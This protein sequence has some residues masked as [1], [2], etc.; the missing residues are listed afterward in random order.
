M[1]NYSCILRLIFFIS[2][3]FIANGNAIAQKD[4][5][6]FSGVFNEWKPYRIY[7]PAAYPQSKEKYPVIYFFHG[8][9]G[10]HQFAVE[11]IQQLVNENKVIFVAWNGRSVPS[12]MR[13]YN[14]GYHS[15][16]KYQVQF[17]DYFPEFI[18]YID[19]TYRT[20][21]DRSHRAIMGHSMGGFMSFF[22]AGK[23][24]QLVG[25][26]VS[27]K[28][29]S[30]FFI[31]YPANHSLYLV[32][33]MF[34][35]FNGV[36]LRFH[37]STID[38]LVHL[39]TEVYN[40]AKREH[41]LNLDY[42]VYPG[43][44]AYSVSEFKDAFLFVTASFKHPLAAPARWHHA[45]LYPNF[46][47][48]GY[49]V[50]SNLSQPGFI[51]LRGVTK[52][53]MEILTKKWQPDGIAIPGVNI[54]VKTASIYKSNSS[55]TLLDYNLAEDNKKSSPVTS[56]SKGSI[57]FSVNHQ[58]HQI[59]IFEKNGQ[60]EIVFVNHRVNNNS[61]FLD[62]QRQCNLQLRLLNR[63]GST[64]KK[65]KITISSSTAGV[66]IANPTIEIDSIASGSLSWVP[67]DFKITV[68]GTPPADGSPPGVRFNLTI[69][70][71]KG[72][73]WNDEFDAPV[74]Y[75]VPG[76]ANIGID[77]GDSEIFGSGNGNNIAEPG[78]TIMIYQDSYRTK[79]FYD[80]PYIDNERL[81]DELQPDKWGDGYAISS[82]IH[83]SKDCP[84]GH[85]IKFL[86]CYEVKEWKTIKR[87]VTWGVFS[88][89]VGKPE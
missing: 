65:L 32:K 69:A 31:G 51:E 55:Y 70:D 25:T 13:P 36:R 28:G 67:A 49:H 50:N 86:A 54:N 34:K 23:F 5:A 12:D 83:I 10:T 30:E 2:I 88:I 72:N 9:Q 35:N 74:Y 40:G 58:R 80:D 18:N 20:I 19:S 63:G 1:K 33:Y 71:S 82:L 57:R 53:G 61:S 78:E 41:D 73:I 44:H 68:Q 45:D 48:W 84:P 64:V 4:T 38:E 77:D 8:N 89:T 26:A 7:L 87:N 85:V 43:G 42:R 66:T 56:D 17:K 76:F 3:V 14:A 81:Y 24:P 37:N 60:A 52:G 59:G 47:V 46:E 79:L 15:N 62:H 16:I 11:N 22:L 29:S 27:M 39:N 75:D 6:H 21:A